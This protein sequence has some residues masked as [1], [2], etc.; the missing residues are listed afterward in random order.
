MMLRLKNNAFTRSL[1]GYHLVLADCGDGCASQLRSAL[2][3][4]PVEMVETPRHADIVFVSGILTHALLPRVKVM[5]QGLSKPYFTV[6]VGTCMG[7]LNKAFEDPSKNYAIGARLK[8]F[9]PFDL[10]IEGCPPS[11]DAIFNKIETLITYMDITPEISVTL[12]KRVDKGV[13]EP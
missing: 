8:T 9:L 5:F 4:L 12:D 7:A 10:V 3:K 2:E 11:D 13:F 1:K 6:K